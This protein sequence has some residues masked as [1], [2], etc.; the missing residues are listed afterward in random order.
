MSRFLIKSASVFT[1]LLIVGGLT[2]GCSDTAIPVV[3]DWQSRTVAAVREYIAEASREQLGARC[4]KFLSPDF[5]NQNILLLYPAEEFSPQGW[6]GPHLDDRVN[7]NEIDWDN[8]VVGA[9]VCG[10]DGATVV[11]IVFDRGSGEVIASAVVPGK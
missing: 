3:D 8:V 2:G 7:P 4:K 5:F 11:A 6:L 1:L 10:A 9:L